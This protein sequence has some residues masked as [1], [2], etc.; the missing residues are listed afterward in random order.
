LGEKI[1]RI[2]HKYINT[3]F[4]P[5]LQKNVIDLILKIGRV[6]VFSTRA[7]FLVIF[8]RIRL[9]TRVKILRRNSD[10]LK[11]WHVLA[12]SACAA[13]QNASIVGKKKVMPIVFALSRDEKKFPREILAPKSFNRFKNI[14]LN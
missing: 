7:Q 6:E 11:K 10:F 9:T 5:F 14:R 1:A 4:E 13:C 8:F 2:S 12:T 3:E